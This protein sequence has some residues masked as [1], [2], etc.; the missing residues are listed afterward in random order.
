MA[1]TLTRYRCDECGDIHE[2][3]DN[4]REC[5]APTISEVYQCSV[6]H[7]KFDDEDEADKHCLD[8]DEDQPDVPSHA[9]LE[10]HGQQR[11]PL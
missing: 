4:A 8:H 7:A 5:C 3:E 11:L 6:C 1:T 10:A 2:D 9:E